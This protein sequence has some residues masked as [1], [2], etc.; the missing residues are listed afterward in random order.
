MGELSI[1]E[2]PISSGKSGHPD[3]ILTVTERP[4]P[5]APWIGVA[6]E[7]EGLKLHEALV[8]LTPK[9]LR[10][11]LYTC[12]ATGSGKTT[13]IEI[14]IAQDILLGHSF[15]V[16]DMRGNLVQSAL[17]LCHGHVDPSMVKLFDL[18]ETKCPFGFNPLAGEG[19]AYFRALNVL[20]VVAKESESWGVQLAESLRNALMLLAQSNGS[21]IQ[22]EDVF[23]ND[24]FRASLV[25]KMTSESVR[26]FWA[27]Y[28]ELSQDR[29]NAFASAVLNKVSL[30]TGPE[31]LR[32]TL[33]HP[34]PVDLKS[35]L[36]TPGSVTLVSLA[37]DQLH[38][39]A[40]M[41][42]NMMLKTLTREV[43]SRIDIPE[44]HRNPVRMYVDE[45]E[46]FDYDEFETI[47][48]E[49]RKFGLTLVLAHQT[50][51]QLTPRIRS[52]LLN[53]V[54]AKVI[55]RTGREDAAI[56]N[57]DLTGDPKA[58]ELSE[59]PV[60]EAILWKRGNPIVH[61]EVNE[62]LIKNLGTLSP[63]G[64]QFLAD[65]Q[66]HAPVYVEQPRVVETKEPADSDQSSQA[67]AKPKGRGNAVASLEDWL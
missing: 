64:K 57:K 52:L 31:A 1:W 32:R 14:L 65:V 41:T 28:D 13:F 56:L 48:A 66:A 25:A 46:N 39:A 38:G 5:P 17:E 63:E 61:V 51:A 10:T 44:S 2:I 15:I 47:L 29:K 8:R 6:K 7:R 50:L 12:G 21:I 18:R 11:H 53:N 30:I 45:F 27:K 9:D 16:L 3:F 43:F 54:G 55:F 34:E 22:L 23:Y 67:E 35:H 19:E 58:F 24:T 37:V 49:G 60:G 42:G 26:T 40:R 36:D 33:G 62:P 4:I 59:L 20:D